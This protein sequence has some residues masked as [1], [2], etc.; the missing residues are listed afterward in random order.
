MQ[1]SI[2]LPDVNGREPVNQIRSQHFLVAC[3]LRKKALSKS[4]MHFP[5]I[6]IHQD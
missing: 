5:W 4:W 3:F 6:G 1:E 2:L